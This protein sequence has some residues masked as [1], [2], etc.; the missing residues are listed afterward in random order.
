MG[1]GPVLWLYVGKFDN[2]AAYMKVCAWFARLQVPP[3]T[4]EEF[5]EGLSIADVLRREGMEL[6]RDRSRA[7]A[8]K[9][10]WN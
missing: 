10:R 9:A 6:Y 7:L 4:V 3:Q 5:A 8:Q 2:P 1:E